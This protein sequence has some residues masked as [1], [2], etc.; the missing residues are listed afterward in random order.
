MNQAAEDQAAHWQRAYSERDAEEMSWTEA[1]PAESLSLIEAAG[2]GPDAAILD[3]GGGASRLAGELLGAGYRDLTV[4]DISPAALQRARSDLGPRSEEIAWVTADVKQHDFGRRFDLWHDRAV[5]HFM[6][7]RGDRD[8]YL[9]TLER[10]LEPGGHVVLATF[11]PEGPTECSGLPVQR[12][13]AES[14]AHLLGRRYR[15]E[16]SRVVEHRTPSGKAQQFTFAL[17]SRRPA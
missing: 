14:L 8:A 10:S 9:A 4:A 16:D 15:L 6:V 7:E 5:L 3:V 12:Y 1:T 11:G 17:L 13:D 2:L